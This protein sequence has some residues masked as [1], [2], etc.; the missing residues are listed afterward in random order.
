MAETEVRP[1]TTK[2]TP[3]PSS[4]GH[5][6]FFIEPIIDLMAASNGLDDLANKLDGEDRYGE[7]NILR[8]LGK[9]VMDI[10]CHF[11]D[12]NWATEGGK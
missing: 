3:S 6:A 9:Q 4:V 7:A 1:E 2:A 11:N 8:L 12:N 5:S 10:A